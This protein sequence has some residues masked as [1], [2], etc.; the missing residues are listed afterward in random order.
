MGLAVPIKGIAA[1]RRKHSCSPVNGRRRDSTSDV[2][3]N[4]NCLHRGHRAT[5]ANT[6]GH[7]NSHE[8][9][10]SISLT[11]M[12]HGVIRPAPS[13]LILGPLPSLRLVST[14]E[15]NSVQAF[16]ISRLTVTAGPCT[17]DFLT[18]RRLSI[19]GSTMARITATGLLE[20][21]TGSTRPLHRRSH[22]VLRI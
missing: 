16:P 20:D 22:S 17:I 19:P 5:E 6:L 7:L 9:I 8:T 1:K 18:T 12:A 14:N 21:A 13:I 10:R 4:P 2:L 11:R 15:R 3:R